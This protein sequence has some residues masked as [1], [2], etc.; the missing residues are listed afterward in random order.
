M[1]I[2]TDL[3]RCGTMDVKTVFVVQHVRR[4]SDGREDVK[5]IGVYTSQ[6]LAQQAVGRFGLLEGFRDHPN[7]FSIDRYVV[8][9]DYWA[10]GFRTP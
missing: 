2:H 1:L 3:Q 10:E 4:F 7:G 5:L 9:H 6:T 8:D